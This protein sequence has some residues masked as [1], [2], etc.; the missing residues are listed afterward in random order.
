[1]FNFALYF[2]NHKTLLLRSYLFVI[3]LFAV[4]GTGTG[5]A[6]DVAMPDM[7]F[8]VDTIVFAP[9]DT[10]VVV[11]DS[12]GMELI[13]VDPNREPPFKTRIE[14]KATDSVTFNMQINRAF[15]YSET[16]VNYDDIELKAHNTEFD[17]TTRI[18][19]ASGG[20]DSLDVYFGAPEF[21]QGRNEFTSDSMSY[22]FDTGRGIIHRIR[23]QQG[24]GIL[25]ATKAKRYPEGHLHI[26]GGK[27]T[28]CPADH[29]HFY[30]ALKEAKVIPSDLVVFRHAHMVLLD[31]PL[32][33][34]YLPF[35]FFPQTDKE[36]VSGLIPP[37]VGMEISRGL[38]LTGGGYYFAFND[39]IDAQIMADIYSTGT[40]RS[41]LTTRYMKRYKFSGNLNM[42]YGVTVSGEKGLDQMRTMQYSAQWSHRQDAKAN[43]YNSFQAS[44][45]Y[46]TSSY[47]REFNYTNSTL[48]YNN[49][50][51]SSISFSRRWPNTPF[52]FSTNARANQVSTT[53]NTVID[54]PNFTFRM[55][56][57]FPFRRKE[58]VGKARWYEDI[59]LQYDANL[60]NTISGQEDDLFS[61][62]NI[63][64]MKN[65]F[66][67]RIPFSINFKALRFFNITPSVNYTGVLYGSQ[68]RKEFIPD[69]ID[70]RTGVIA[71]DTIRG[72][73]YAHALSP[74]LS[75]S[76]TPKFFLM[77][78]YG[79]NSKVEAIRTVIS[80]NIGVSYIPDLSRFFDYYRTIDVQEGRQPHRY[81]IFEGQG[82][83]GTPAAP[84]QSGSVNLGIN[85]NIEM[86]VRS[87]DSLAQSRKIKL[88]NNISASTR[89]N[90]FADSMN[91]SNISLSA[92]TTL[93]GLNLTASGAVDPY[94]LTP[95]GTRI[96]QYG[97]RL[98]NVNFNTGI[99][100]PLNRNETRDRD[101]NDEYAYF[102]VP[103]NLNFSYGLNYSKPRFDGQF[104]QTLSFSGN[105]SFTKNWSLNFSSSYDFEAR[106]I[107]Y[108]SASITR[109]LCCWEMSLSF[110]PFGVHKFYFFKINVKSNTLRDLK[111]ER[112][113][114][115]RDFS[116][117]G[118]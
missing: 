106:K 53:G 43:P 35:G 32:F 69:S 64:N 12:I 58:A 83:F 49:S 30:L 107:A 105:I 112:R 5:L 104:T 80:P 21:K 62:Y 87:T 81:S 23:T 76:M 22:N 95:E 109:G 55:D 13:E 113:K 39:H 8:P 50:K 26:G 85:G 91:L 11:G 114:S 3:V 6:Q 1:M 4:L 118:W 65:G 66:Q 46:S 94:R 14:Y 111:Y 20:R 79:P 37:T 10:V 24:E 15:L 28:T 84:G 51:N 99:S 25:H 54:F 57:I 61:D 103:W 16:Q 71:V 31:I 56:R 36:A 29:P 108:T 60:Q 98:T 17:M 52:H 73:S 41:T 45:N 86:K 47:D 38:S 93:F 115:A 90:I 59:A 44:V 97:P 19:Y 18:V 2:L 92:N 7:T 78:Q 72:L 75:V 63:R 102:D 34:L 96:N 117:E 89:Y 116:R 33:L 48:L 27:Y 68:I 67:H 101:P 42:S 74:S 100:L 70:H 40:W 77:N 110:S 88:L 9:V 82:T